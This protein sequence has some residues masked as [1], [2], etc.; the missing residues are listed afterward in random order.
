MLYTYKTNLKLSAIFI[1]Y[2]SSLSACGAGRHFC[3]KLEIS[4]KNSPHQTLSGAQLKN[5]RKKLYLKWLKK[6]ATDRRLLP[7]KRG[8]NFKNESQLTDVYLATAAVDH[9]L[10]YCTIHRHDGVKAE[11]ITN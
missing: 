7:K 9:M 4:S 6:S 8:E 5:G 10:S 11:T 2:A 3:T 1:V